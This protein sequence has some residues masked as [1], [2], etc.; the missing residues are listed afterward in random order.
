MVFYVN[1]NLLYCHLEEDFATL[2]S[3]M[4]RLQS[5]YGTGTRNETNSTIL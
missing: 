2:D 4:E 3:L 5:V 1:P